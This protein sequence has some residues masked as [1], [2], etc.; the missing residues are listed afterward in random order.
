MTFLEEL[1]QQRWD[2]HRYYHHNRINQSLHLFSATCFLA[3]YVL[4]F[5]NPILAAFFGWVLAMVPF[6]LA[7]TLMVVAPDYLQELKLTEDGKGLVMKGL[8]LEVIGIVWIR[9]L[10]KM[11]V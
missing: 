4:L 11:D 5:I 8:V 10:L 7:A 3:T 9:R 1:H 6:A 2:D